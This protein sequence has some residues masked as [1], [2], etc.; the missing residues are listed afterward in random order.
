L[1]ARGQASV[2]GVA[3]HLQASQPAATQTLAEMRKLDLVAYETGRD[4]RERLVML[5]DK[6][7][8]MADALAPTWDAIGR[9]AKQLDSELSYPLSEI[10]DEALSALRRKSFPDRISECRSRGGE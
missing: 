2:S 6:A 8:A 3:S 10:L 7:R 9:A 1:L 4:K 5:T